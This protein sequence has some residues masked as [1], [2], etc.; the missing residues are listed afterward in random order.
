[1]HAYLIE[2]H[3]G[4]E[5]LE[6]LLGTLDDARNNLY[7]HLDAKCTEFQPQDVA[8]PM[9]AQLHW[10]VKRRSVNWGG[11]PDSCRVGSFGCCT[12]GL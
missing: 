4:K 10:S 2:A 7:I 12:E 9:H 8:T 11:E 5:Q 6:M 1:M 3:Q